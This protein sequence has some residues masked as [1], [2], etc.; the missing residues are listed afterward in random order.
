MST[1]VAKKSATVHMIGT[2][3]QVDAGVVTR[4][5]SLIV[6]SVKRQIGLQAELVDAMR[7]CVDLK[8][9]K[10]MLTYSEESAFERE[11]VKNF[12]G[13]AEKYGLVQMS[14]I[15]TKSN[16]IKA[17]ENRDVYVKGLA[18][19][20]EF[21]H[22]ENGKPLAKVPEG[23]LNL[24]NERYQSNGKDASSTMYMRDI[25][26][27][28]KASADLTVAVK[29]KQNAEKRAATQPQG[30]GT[31]TT[32]TESQTAQG[33]RSGGGTGEAAVMHDSVAEAMGSLGRVVI[34]AQEL[35]TDQEIVHALNT[36]FAQF[37]NKLAAIREARKQ[38]PEATKRQRP[39]KAAAEAAKAKKAAE[40][41]P[42]LTETDQKNIEEVERMEALAK[43]G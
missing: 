15:P 37:G 28:K 23:F 25:G 36:L 19:W 32:Q 14:Y 20:Y 11:G 9:A 13:L 3:I 30:N 34:Q 6:Q 12:S 22:K 29:A 24:W 42:E 43:A 5:A 8:H 27:A 38:T 10:A 41:L 21:E 33:L 40:A 2:D 1:K 16:I 17:I 18:A 39:N 35:M 4:T 7:A 31:L 26:I